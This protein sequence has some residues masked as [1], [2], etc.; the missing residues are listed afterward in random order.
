MVLTEEY[1]VAAL[2]T[3][4]LF[5]DGQVVHKVKGADPE[6]LRRIIQTLVAE[7]DSLGEGSGS[8]EPWFGAEIPRGYLDITDQIET[9]N[10]ELLNAEEG[11][12]SVAVLFENSKPDALVNKGKGSAKDFV[13]S[14]ADDQLL[15]FVPFQGSVKLHTLQITSVPEEG[16]DEISRPEV[17]HLYINRPQNMDFNEADDAEPTQVITLTPEDWNSD[18]TANIN[19]RFVKFQKTTTLILYVQK[20]ADGAD[21]VR[22]DRIKFIGDAGTKREMGKLQKI[23]DVE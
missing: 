23:S 1:R 14:G 15:L 20:G 12:G 21:A 5:Q 7:V 16:Q 10:C 13:R 4:I 6:A 8:G 3:F 9:R 22:L 19:L 18:G 17:L 11:A 2:P